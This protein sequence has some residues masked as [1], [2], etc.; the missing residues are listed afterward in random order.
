MVSVTMPSPE[1]SV[2][3]EAPMV[4]ATVDTVGWPHPAKAVSDRIN[5]RFICSR[6]GEFGD[7]PGR[8]GSIGRIG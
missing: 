7:G 5:K 2:P 8:S 1:V 3:P 4:A 6:C